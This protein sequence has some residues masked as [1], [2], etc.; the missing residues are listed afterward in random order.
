MIGVNVVP[1]EVAAERKALEARDLAERQLRESE[2]HLALALEAGQLGFWDWHVPSGRSTFGGRRAAMLGHAPDEIAPD[3][4]SW[5]SRVH[6]DDLG[7]VMSAVSAHPEGRTPFHEFEH[8]MRTR[9]SEWVWVLDRG[10]VVE[11]DA[12]GRAVRAIGTHLDVSERHRTSETLRDADRRKDEF[13]AM[14]GHE[15]RNPLSPLTNALRLLSADPAIDGHGA[16]ALAIAIRQ[17]SHLRRLVDDLLDVSRI[18]L[19]RIALQP[20]SL[21]VAAVLK[22]A[23]ETAQPGCDARRQGL[24]QDAV[25]TGLRA[26]RSGCPRG[27]TAPWRRSGWWIRASAS[28]LARWSRCSSCFCRASPASASPRAG[29]ASA[30]LW[31]AGWPACL[32]GRCMPKARAAIWGRRSC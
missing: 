8:R 31:C 3:F 15:L 12:R 20:E 23:I 13:I 21:D 27:P 7:R 22:A 6:P 30:S 9:S 25:D 26:E 5:R 19:E 10:Q 24:I 17:A 1:H 29:S 11:R 4:E 18:T 16:Q 28:T 14:L 2:Q 32:A